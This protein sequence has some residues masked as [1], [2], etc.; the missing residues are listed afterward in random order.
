MGRVR[1]ETRHCLVDVDKL[2]ARH[3]EAVI[4]QG[5]KSG[6][7]LRSMPYCRFWAI[8]NFFISPCQRRF[9]LIFFHKT[10]ICIVLSLHDIDCLYL[11]DDMM[12]V[13][14]IRWPT[15]PVGRIWDVGETFGTNFP[16]RHRVFANSQEDWTIL[17]SKT[18]T[19]SSIP[20]K[21]LSYVIG[22]APFRT[23][24]INHPTVKTKFSVLILVYY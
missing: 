13:I 12:S 19:H 15:I 20:S 11:S 9:E 10:G 6:K 14:D 23:S 5:G 8:F 1:F 24:N 16:N 22:S 21:K 4:C 2:R 7:F 18:N 17:Q 3:G